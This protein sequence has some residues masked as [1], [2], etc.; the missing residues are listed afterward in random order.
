[1]QF[2]RF[3]VTAALVAFFIPNAIRSADVLTQH[4]DPARTGANLSENILKPASVNVNGFG[5]LFDLP[6][7]SFIYSQPLVV[8]GLQI[9]DRTRNVVFTA[10]EHNTLYAFDADTGEELWKKNFGPSM[11]TPSAHFVNV[12]G[13]TPYHDLNPEIGITSTPVIDRSTGTL[14]F[15]SFIQTSITADPFVTFHHHLHAVDLTDGSE[16]FG[17]PVEIQGCVTSAVALKINAGTIHRGRHVVNPEQCF[18]PLQEMQRPGLL[19]VKPADAV[20]Q[21]ILA[22]ASHGDYQPY[23]G[24]VMSYQADN[25]QKRLGIWVSSTDNSSEGNGAGIWQAGMGPALDESGNLYVMVGNGFFDGQTSFAES[26][27]RFSTAGG[28]IAMT[29][30]FTPC[31]QSSLDGMDEDVGSSGPLLLINP[32]MNPRPH[33]V[34]GAG[35]QGRLYLLNK[36]NLGGFKAC[37]PAACGPPNPQQCDPQVAQEFQAVRSP[38]QETHH[39]HGSPVT[40][41][42]PVRGPV[43]YLWGENDHLRAYPL[44]LAGS[45]WRYQTFAGGPPAWAVSVASSPAQ[46][47]DPGKSYMTGGMLSISANGDHDAI[48]WATTPTNNDANAR[49]SPGILRAY[50]ANDLSKELWNSYQNVAQDDFGNYAKFTPV[51]VANGKVYVPTFSGHLSVYGLLTRTVT[52]ARL[53]LIQNGGFENGTTGW[54]GTA[55]RFASEINYPFYGKRNGVLCTTQPFDATNTSDI[56]SPTHPPAPLNSR[57]SQTV[58]AP[59]AGHYTLHALCGTNILPNNFWLGPGEVQLGVSVNGRQVANRVITPSVGYQ[60]YEIDFDA[61]QGQQIEIWYAAPGVKTTGP[62]EISKLITLDAWAVI[63]EVELFGPEGK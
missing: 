43:V 12:G 18:N 53:N 9:G 57:L 1:M 47:W 54:S 41:V 22:F 30:S 50:D 20:A 17:G 13:N 56:C 16:K 4:N 58:T 5:K 23:Y 7:D 61:A 52:P 62:V 48:L 15:T 3:A 34:T 55:G 2:R 49:T 38:T 28:T 42:S 63:D 27:L 24:W 31:N 60:S 39:I 25:I 33:Y 37:V 21:V 26:F 40:W 10:T 11:P 45:D 19:L 44:E 8:T 46:P 36:E 35:K 6:V 14:Y 51:T 32:N 29:D 59:A